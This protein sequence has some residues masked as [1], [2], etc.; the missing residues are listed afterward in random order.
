MMLQNP[1]S[2]FILMRQFMEYTTENVTMLG[3]E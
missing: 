2:G 1:I 3:S